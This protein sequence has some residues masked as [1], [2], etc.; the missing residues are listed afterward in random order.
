MNIPSFASAFE[1]ALDRERIR[2]ARVILRIRVFA[3]IGYL[4]FAVLAAVSGP[5][6]TELA[7]FYC[8]TSAVNLA[9]S[10]IL[11]L[12]CRSPAALRR[13][14]LYIPLGDVTGFFVV[15][16]IGIRIANALGEPGLVGLLVGFAMGPALLYLLAAQLSMSP[17]VI[18]LTAALGTIGY[19]Y[20]V[21]GTFGTPLGFASGAVQTGIAAAIALYVPRRISGVLERTASEEIQRERLRRYFSPSVADAILAGGEQTG[22]APEEREVTVLFSDLRDFTALSERMQSA[23]VVALLNEVHGAMAAVLFAHGGTLDKFIGDGLM[24]YFGAPL[25]QEDHARRA[26]SCALEMIST[27]ESLN[28][29]RVAR[30]ESPVRMGIGVHTG[31]VVL[32]DIGPEDRKEY[33]AIGDAV[34]VASRIEGLTK[35]INSPILVSRS[36]RALTGDAFLWTDAEPLPVKGKALPLETAVPRRPG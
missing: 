28:A 3:W 31:R 13:S 21:A 12:V 24:A 8:W 33:T 36:T 1:L 17:R 27:L 2:G 26:V 30:G 14:W 18:V 32:G 20:L 10:V 35:Q 19:G 4:A 25:P 23:Q 15:Q 29:R 16:I 7:I 6:A 5:K 34:N 11:L 22:A 9:A